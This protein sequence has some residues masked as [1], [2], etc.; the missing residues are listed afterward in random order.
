MNT[1]KE[2]FERYSAE[3]LSLLGPRTQRDYVRHIALLTR[4]FGH[5]VPTVNPIRPK[6]VGRWPGAVCNSSYS[7]LTPRKNLKRLH[8][9]SCLDNRSPFNILRGLADVR[10][11]YQGTAPSNTIEFLFD[12][13]DARGADECWPWLGRKLKNGYGLVPWFNK[14]TTAHRAVYAALHGAVGA[15]IDVC[16][17]CDNRICCNPM[18]LWAGSHYENMRDMYDKGRNVPYR[19]SAETLHKL[20]VAQKLRAAANP[21]RMAGENSPSARL[22][23]ADVLSMLDRSQTIATHAAKHRVCAAM[24][25]MIRNGSRWGSVTGIQKAPIKRREKRVI[26]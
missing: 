15:G 10:P 16:H 9:V 25:V 19:R 12:Q 2:V 14:T 26:Q 17:T 5:H 24:V 8:S 7:E 13:I 22:T 1:M 4:D 3:C 23:S 20:S 6:D 21:G 11:I 18:H